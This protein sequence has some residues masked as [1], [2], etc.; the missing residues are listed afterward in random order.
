M[1]PARDLHR[2]QPGRRGAASRPPTTS[3]GASAAHRCRGRQPRRARVL[4]VLRLLRRLGRTGC[5]TGSGSRLPLPVLAIALP[6][7]ISFFTFQ[8]ISYVVDVYRRQI[9]PA[10]LDRLRGLPGVLPAPRR[11]A[12]RPRARVP[13]A[14]RARRAT[15]RRSTRPGASSSSPLGLFK[16]VVIADLPGDAHRRP[17]LRQPRR[18]LRASRCWSAIYA[19]RRADLLRLLRLHR[20]G[21]RARAAARLPVPAE[22]RPP[23]RR[24]GRS[25]TSGGAGTSPCRAGCATTCTSR[26]AATASGERATYRNLMLT[27]LLG[28]LWHGASWTFVVWGG[29]HGAGLAVER[30]WRERKARQPLGPAPGEPA[31]TGAQGVLVGAASGDAAASAPACPGT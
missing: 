17:G 10:T 30:W 29:I 23:L 2:R 8:A 14:A 22:L 7:G 15:R 19:L 20:H 18:A 24:A 31:P 5:S 9:E 12:D 4:Q 21:D 16:K 6:V 25:R 28:G 11:R 26:S 27:M 3:A 1:L 13:A